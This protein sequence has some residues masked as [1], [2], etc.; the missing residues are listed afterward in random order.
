MFWPHR[1][2]LLESFGLTFGTGSEDSLLSWGG[3][4]TL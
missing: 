1:A 4:G 3:A 2:C